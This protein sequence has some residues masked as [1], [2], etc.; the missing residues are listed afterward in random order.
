M[1]ANLDSEKAVLG[2][3]IQHGKDGYA[4]LCDIVDESVFT[5]DDAKITYN[6]VTSCLE[7]S[8]TVDKSLFFSTAQS[9]SYGNWLGTKKD[10][11]AELFTN[12]YALDNSR[13]HAAK[14]TKLK[15]ARFGQ[16]KL[17][18]AL[19]KLKEV[20]GDEP[21]DS[22]VSVVESP[23]FDVQKLVNQ[24][25]DA[26]GLIGRDIIA[27]LQDLE[28]NPD[29]SVAIPTGMKLIDQLL[30]GGIR[31]G[32]YD[33][34]AAQYKA[35]KSSIALNVALFVAE[36]LG[37]PVLYL[38]TEM[39]YREHYGRMLANKTSIPITSIE[40]SR[41]FTNKLFKNQLYD[42]GKKI[43]KLP[44]THERI[45]GKKFPEIISLMRRWLVKNVGYHESGEF[46][47]CLIIYDYFKLMDK[48]DVK[49]LKEYEALGYQAMELK[50]FLG[51]NQVA[52]LAFVQ[53][54]RE[55]D[56]AQSD[57]LAW[58]ATSISFYERKTDE[59]MKTHGV[60]NGNRKFR[61]KCG[62]FAGEGDFDNYVNIDFNG[63]LCQVRDICTAY[64]LKEELKNGKG[65][66][67]SGIDDSEAELTSF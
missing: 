62:R 66:F 7:V 30:N 67:N 22:I 20:T 8:D 26:G 13:I 19:S 2:T 41:V 10:F 35:G 54:N 28:E 5:D 47:N 39:H 14:I 11:I 45:A 34:I 48:S 12:T 51:E 44:I 42:A 32:G 53:V 4:E 61:F 1:L 3:I 21:F 9:L 43:E 25:H 23:G 18:A 24:G 33:L 16:A 58:N 15:I 27:Y 56:I 55:G 37:I 40:R 59:E 36:K 31:K 46:N 63:E 49:S 50:D 57:R 38:D 6:I 52:C 60:I 29:R 17:M 64:E 65:K